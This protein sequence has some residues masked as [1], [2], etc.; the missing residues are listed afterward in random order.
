MCQKLIFVH[1]KGDAVLIQVNA[2]N[3]ELEDIKQL[4]NFFQMFHK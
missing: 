2:F 3:I 1:E 4:S